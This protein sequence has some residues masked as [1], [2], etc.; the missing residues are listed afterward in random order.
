[1]KKRII[2]ISGTVLLILLFSLIFVVMNQHDT[3]SHVEERHT[4]NSLPPP[5]PAPPPA[6][7][8]SDLPRSEKSLDQL[9]QEM[10]IGAIA[11]NAPSRLNISD[12]QQIQLLL[13]LSE[14]ME[15]LQEQVQASGETIGANIKV[16]NRM[17]ARLTGTMF[18]ISAVTPE[19]QAISKSLPT[20]W[21]W[22]VSP[23]KEGNYNLHLT[24]TALLEVDGR[25]TPRTIRTFDQIISV[26]VTTSQRIKGFI[27]DNWRWFWAVILV[28]LFGWVISKL[29]KLV[30]NKEE[31]NSKE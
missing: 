31:N 24:L 22:E 1:M 30:S 26:E 27:N 23:I 13:S 18:N 2:L 25:E 6:P 28:P 29:K 19:V 4:E 21:R 14:P 7:P 15:Q 16:S 20:E 3:Y 5:P 11:F 10:E 9:L 8:P 12:S 17:E